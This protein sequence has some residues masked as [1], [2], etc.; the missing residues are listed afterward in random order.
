[1]SLLQNIKKNYPAELNTVTIGGKVIAFITDYNQCYGD[2]ITQWEIDGIDKAPVECKYTHKP[3][4]LACCNG[5]C[6]VREFNRSIKMEFLYE[7]IG[8]ED[9]IKPIEKEVEAEKMAEIRNLC[10]N[11]KAEDYDLTFYV[12]Q[13]LDYLL[14]NEAWKQKKELDSAK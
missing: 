8:W 4:L 5:L 10:P 14:R 6:G 12:D 9:K 13:R 7:A 2:F 11:A 3:I 1:M